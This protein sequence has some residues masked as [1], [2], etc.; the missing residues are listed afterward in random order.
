MALTDKKKIL[1]LSHTSG[2]SGAEECLL[3]LVK[4]L[5]RERFEPLVVMPPPD[6]PLREAMEQLGVRVLVRPLR[7]W[8]TAPSGN[9]LRELA[10]DFY[11]VLV[12]CLGV[13]PRAPILKA[14][15]SAM[16]L[17]NAPAHG[18]IENDLEQRVLDLEQ[19][20]REE[21]IALVH[22]NTSVIWEGAFAASRAGVP[23]VWHL[24]EIMKGYPHLTMLLPLGMVYSVMT[25]L[26]DRVVTV[27]DAVRDS[28]PGAVSRRNLLTIPNGIDTQKRSDSRRTICVGS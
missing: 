20:I 10:L 28:I 15:R 19:I 6:G 12:Q 24:H 14:Y 11:R 4:Y 3:T 17:L 2:I 7:W 16:G 27:S 13:A 21:N 9:R 25:K 23:H 18:D 26:S 1:F 5:D 8:A 22:S